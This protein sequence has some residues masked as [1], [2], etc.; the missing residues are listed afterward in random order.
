[1]TF[2]FAS[3]GSGSKGN[4]TLVD[5][6]GVR[7]LIDCGF[8][9]KDVQARLARL[10]LEAEQLDA[11]LVTH[12]HSDHAGGVARLARRFNKPVYGTHG[13]V[14]RMKNPE[15]LTIRS[16][17]ADACFAIG[18]L[19][20]T[21]FSVP[22][23]AVQPCQFRFDVAD[24]SLAVLSDLGHVTPHVTATLRDLDALMLE[25]NHDPKML[26]E[27]PYP[28]MLRAR[29]AGDWGHLSNQQAAQLLAQ[30]P[31]QRLQH[32]W[33]THLS[34]TNNRPDLALMAIEQGLGAP[35][36]LARC[37]TQLDGFAW[38]EVVG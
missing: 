5:A 36:P 13:T 33:L 6:G 20:V 9:L 21:A 14:R 27:G 24:R 4:G 18:D 25:F 28:P 32:L 29:V 31:H 19:Q 1:M 38:C 34:E 12:E 15:N 11:I 35:H 7:V 2:R 17:D 37:A 22:H 26:A 8:G 16:F 23:D 10:G 3:L 30:L